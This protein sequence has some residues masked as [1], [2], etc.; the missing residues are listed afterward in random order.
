M[1]HYFALS[2]AK[3]APNNPIEEFYIYIV[4]VQGLQQNYDMTG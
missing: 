1:P 3:K 4:F 2:K